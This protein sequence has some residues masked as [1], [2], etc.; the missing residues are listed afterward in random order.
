MHIRLK[1][2]VKSDI[3]AGALTGRKTLGLLLERIDREPEKP[4]QVYLDFTGIEVATASFLRECIL[5]FRDTV[6]RRWPSYYPV[7]A[8]ANDTVTEELSILLGPQRDVLMLCTLDEHGSPG[9]PRLVG[10]LEPK[11]RIT[12]DLVNKLGETNAGELM[13]TANGTEDVGQTAW[14]NRLAS[15]K[16][17][18]LVMELSHGRAKRY[19]PLPL[20]G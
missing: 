15:L 11:Q 9:A 1:D 7:V 12:Y 14:N 18:G 8:N 20:G 5:E 19:R 6:R 13:R 17:L 3:L 4:E 2:L 16:R 10:D